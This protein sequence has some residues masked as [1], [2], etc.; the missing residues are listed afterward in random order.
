MAGTVVFVALV[1]TGWPPALAILVVL[2]ALV[3]VGR[4]AGVVVAAGLNP[5]ITTLAAGA[6]IFGIVA[7]ATNGRIVRVG[8]HPVS[9]GN[10]TIAGI[11]L[12]VLVFVLFTVAVGV[13]HDADRF[14]PRDD[15]G[16]RQRGRRRGER[17]LV[18]ARSPSVRS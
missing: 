2:V 17:H 1:G 3:V 7:D 4:P 15:A 12:E 6:I 18:R 5:V 13:L 14:R 11:P 9:W 16:R 10:S 8:D